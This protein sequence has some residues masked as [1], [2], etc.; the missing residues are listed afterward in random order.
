L[1]SCQNIANLSPDE[2]EKYE[3]SL[4]ILN[5][6]TIQDAD[7]AWYKELAEKDKE[8]ERLK[9]MLGL[10]DTKKR[11]TTRTTKAKSK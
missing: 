4:K 10:K 11:R 1:A 8:I 5:M 2:Y 3:Q 9:R 7:R 6:Y